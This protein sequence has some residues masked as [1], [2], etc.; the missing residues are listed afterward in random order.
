V[1]TIPVLSLKRQVEQHREAIDEAISRVLNSGHF[2]LG[3]EVQKFEQEF[4]EYLGIEHCIS[5]ANGTNALEIA[6]RAVGV[7]AGDYIVG[8]ANAGGY[9]AVAAHTIGARMIYSDIDERTM[10]ISV[11]SLEDL[12]IVAKVRGHAI[13]AIVV[14]HLF[15]SVA[16]V[17]KILEIARRY[18]LAIIEDCAQAAGSRTQNKNAGTFGDIATFSFYPTKNLG[19]FGDAGA[20]VTESKFLAQSVYKLRQYGWGEKYSIEN[21]GGSNSRMDEIQAAILRIKLKS[22]DAENSAR[23]AIHL[24]YEGAMTKIGRLVNAASDEMY[25][26]HLAVLDIIH[27]DR[28]DVRKWLGSQGIAS[29]VHYPI[30][31]HHQPG[32]EEGPRLASLQN[33]ESK[34]KSILTIPLD[35]YL[36]SGE[37]AAIVRALEDF[38]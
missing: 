16:P 14:T 13:K 32:L 38:E 26:G 11:A 15:G 18:G 3:G 27:H 12:L 4:A 29:E 37:T 20:I 7:E 35:P 8:V 33:T 17:T 6:M 36:S 2:I 10:Q 28:Q 31:D 9:S 34:S 30:P 24:Q 23:R 25:N 21:S 1:N 19:A 22:L 5:V